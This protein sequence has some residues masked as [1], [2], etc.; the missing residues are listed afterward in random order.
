[1]S[2]HVNPQSRIRKSNR[3]AWATSDGALRIVDAV[4][5][6]VTP[7]GSDTCQVGRWPAGPC[8][9]WSL[10]FGLNDSILV[11]G[12]VDGGVSL[13]TLA[14]PREPPKSIP[15]PS[16]SFVTSVAFNPAG[17]EL[18]AGK[19][20]KSIAVW[21]VTTQQKQSEWHEK[22]PLNDHL[23]TV[24]AVAFSPDGTILASGSWDTR[25]ILWDV[26]RNAR[27]GDPLVGHQANVNSVAFSPDGHNLV[28]GGQDGELIL[29]VVNVNDWK[30]S[31]CRIANR[32]LQNAE[33]APYIRIRVR[34][35]DTP[36]NLCPVVAHR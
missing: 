6:Q 35:M 5:G 26:E 14:T 22:A 34:G 23:Q 33:W 15:G 11:A 20:D 36:E 29:W 31:A 18:A 27:L 2:N 25:V 10:A 9:K 30:R 4:N 7:L 8:P 1:V 3:L 13:W 32:N 12:R 24:S 21:D 17:T 16:S 19:W 28:S